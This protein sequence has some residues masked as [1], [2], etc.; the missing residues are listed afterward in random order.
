ME[1][2]IF[3]P[4]SS[5]W[6]VESSSRESFEDALEGT[7]IPIYSNVLAFFRDDGFD[8]D[9]M[10]AYRPK[11]EDNIRYDCCYS[12]LFLFNKKDFYAGFLNGGSGAKILDLK[13]FQRISGS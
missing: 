4:K 13:Y 8:I 1:N 3:I 10:D 12:F 9:I 2:H 6:L 7:D 5:F 11:P